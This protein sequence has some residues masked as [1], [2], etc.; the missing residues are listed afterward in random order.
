MLLISLLNSRLLEDLL[1]DSSCES[2][3]TLK[4]VQGLA[5]ALNCLTEVPTFFYSGRL[6][7][8][9]GPAVLMHSVLGL[10]AIRFLWYSILKAPWQSLPVELLGGVLHGLT[11]P[12]VTTVA[13][14]VA[15]DGTRTTAVGIVYAVMD[16]IGTVITKCVSVKLS[17]NVK[18]M[19]GN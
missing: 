17:K 13:N 12:V 16:T 10:W 7:E 5:L 18:Q 6:I 11:Y 3:R 19:C 14:A 8:R 1:V 4:L 15:T 2:R 9:Y